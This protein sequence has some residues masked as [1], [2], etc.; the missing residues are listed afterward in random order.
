[1]DSSLDRLLRVFSSLLV[2]VAAGCGGPNTIDQ[3]QFTDDLCR[4]GTLQAL[5]ALE[6]AES[7]DY[8]E[9]RWA[10]QNWD[11]E[12]FTAPTLLDASGERCS[13]ASDAEACNDAFDALPLE[14][15]FIWYSGGFDNTSGHR[16]LALTRGDE[17]RAITTQ[18]GLLDLLGPID[19][20]GDAALL[21]Y[22]DGRQIL[23]DDGDEVGVD[24]DGYVI[25]TRTGDG[26]GNDIEEHVLLV[27]PDGSMEVIQTV[28]IEKGDATCA[29]GRLPAGLCTT[30]RMAGA[31]DPVG[32]Y[33]ARMAYLEAAA[34]PAFG[35]LAR[36]LSVHGAP[37]SMVRAALRS[38]R[39]EVRHAKVTARLAR[40]FGGRPTAPTVDRVAPRPLPEVAADNAAEGCIRETYGALVAHAQARRARDPQLR[41]AL[42]RIAQEETRHAALSW[43]LSQWAESRMN[44]GQ[45]RAVARSTANALEQLESELT[46]EHHARVHDIAGM[47]TPDRAR[48]LYRGLAQ[49]L[50]V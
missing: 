36:E 47:P 49:A 14:S 32:E 45:R 17:A 6:P 39:D 30:R 15:E 27:R 22:L 44:A 9:L 8:L 35:Q 21:A 10:E 1:M 46:Q 41:R 16:S 28:L 48:S 25:H 13:G 5:D 38:R 11:T 31:T 3:E 33:L 4:A 18:A 37:R 23:C 26:C 40:R 7:V 43:S 29:A 24:D 12:E 50:F 20:P 34:V 19:A 2:P 42:G